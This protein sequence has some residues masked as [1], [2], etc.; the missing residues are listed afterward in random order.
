[1]KNKTESSKIP[2]LRVVK[3]ACS[4]EQLTKRG[5][6]HLAINREADGIE[7]STKDISTTSDKH[8]KDT[9]LVYSTLQ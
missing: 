1:M 4:T 5:I 8:P 3:K 2:F 6:W 7:Q 9:S